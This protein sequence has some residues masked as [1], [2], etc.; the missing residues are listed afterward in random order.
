M[1]H[2]QKK[3]SQSVK[4]E[5]IN[6]KEHQGSIFDREYDAIISEDKSEAGAQQVA[7]VVG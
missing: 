1:M 2:V 3:V 4:K 7:K 6:S 5:H